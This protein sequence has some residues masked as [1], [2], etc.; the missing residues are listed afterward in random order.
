METQQCKWCGDAHGRGERIEC[1]AAESRSNRIAAERRAADDE[2]N[3]AWYRADQVID[4][5]EG[6]L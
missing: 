1:L 6:C 3:A 4:A 2:D 5:R